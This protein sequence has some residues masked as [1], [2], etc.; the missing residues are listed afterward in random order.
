LFSSNGGGWKKENE[1][2]KHWAKKDK[3]KKNTNAQT[4]GGVGVLLTLEKVISQKNGKR[5]GEH[6]AQNLKKTKGDHHTT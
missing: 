4:E 2:P 6:G 5:R 1:C 3:K